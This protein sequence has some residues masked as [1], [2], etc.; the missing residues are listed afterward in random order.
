MNRLAMPALRVY[1]DGPF[2]RL[3]GASR[4]E[5]VLLA[6]LR[7]GC[8]LLLRENPEKGPRDGLYHAVHNK[9]IIIRRIVVAKLP[10]N[11]ILKNEIWNVLDKT[12]TRTFSDHPFRSYS[13]LKIE[14]QNIK[15]PNRCGFYISFSDMSFSNCYNF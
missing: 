14:S 6:H 15:R 3:Q 5:E 10:V 12:K 7:V 9:S 1:G 8:S 2:R 13:S 11:E 4:R